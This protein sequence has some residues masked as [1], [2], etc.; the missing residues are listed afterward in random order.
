MSRSMPRFAAPRWAAALAAA[1]AMALASATAISAP[2]AAWR[3]P[4]ASDFYTY[5]GTAPLSAIAPGTVLKTRAVPYHV[6][7]LPLPV[8]AIQLL[9][10][11]E[12]QRGE[13]V[14]NATTVIRPLLALR[15]ASKVVAYQSFYDSLNPADQP[16]AAIAGGVGLGP[17]IVNV[18]TALFAP[19][20]LAGH[21]IVIT[22]TEGQD[23]DF[24]AGPEYGIATL[25]G[26]RAA[27]SSSAARI[28]SD[29]E[30]AMMGY[31]GGAIATEWAAELAPE[32]APEIS[33]RLVGSAIGGVLVHPGH[34][35]H[36]VS[37]SKIWAG[38]MPMALIGIARSFGFEVDPYLNA[39]GRELVA[40]MQDASITDVLGRYPGLTWSDVARPEY[41]VPESVPIYVEVVNQLI[42]GT[43]GTPEAPLFIGQGTGGWLEGTDGSK[44]G[45]GKGDGV[46]IA[47]D[48]RSLA[49]EYCARGVAVKYRQYG[50]SHFTSMATWLPQAYAWILGRFAG[51]SAPDNCSSIAPGNRLDPIQV[52]AG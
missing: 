9:Y 43:G 41:R 29:S 10:R 17:A 7:A 36:Y 45:I 6:Q 22:D 52:S 48:V 50:L 25:D 34:N 26:L 15:P 5:D 28:A 3:S 33:E 20:L 19:L 38:I 4:L 39:R 30:I 13:P 11:T 37:G 21:T 32:Y 27:T 8:K 23:A 18:E 51:R 47:G 49:R 14:V 42:M 12:N 24:A 1:L 2:A 35:L 31:S 40:Q 44:P 16:S 46:M